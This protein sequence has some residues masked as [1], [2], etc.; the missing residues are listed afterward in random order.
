MPVR[1]EGQFS[2]GGFFTLCR[3]SEKVE[4][5]SSIGV[6]DEKVPGGGVWGAL[7]F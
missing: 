4:Y 5:P 2:F 7:T 3:R 1:V 6:L